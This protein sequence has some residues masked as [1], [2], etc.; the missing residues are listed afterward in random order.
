MPINSQLS[1]EDITIGEYILARLAQ[2]GL[3]EVHGV[4]G[5]SNL[6]FLDL[7][8]DH[9]DLN[10]VGCCN[11]LN[12]SYAADG[13]ARV[14]KAGIG[15]IVT[16]FGV[17]ELS[18]ANGIAGAYAEQVPILHLVG[19][20]ST[21][22]HAKNVIVHHS[23]G[24]NKLDTYAK[25]SGLITCAASSLLNHPKDAP[26]EIDRLLKAALTECRPVYLS[27]PGDLVDAKI[28]ASNL[29]LDLRQKVVE[30]L[31][32]QLNS[33][34]VHEVLDQ[35][36]NLFLESKK[37]VILLDGKCESFRIQTE[38][39]K[40]AEAIQVPVFTT[41]MAKTT[42]GENHPLFGGLYKGNLSDSHII[43]QVESSDMVIWIGPVASDINTASF[44]FNFKASE[45][46]EFH[47]SHTVVR[48]KQYAS[49]GFRNLLPLLTERLSSLPPK[50]KR[51]IRDSNLP[52]K[53]TKPMSM[54]KMIT[55]EEFWPLWAEHFFEPNDII[56]GETGTSAFGLLEV[57]IPD[58]ARLL[59]QML[60]ASIGWSTGACLGAAQAA[61]E[62]G[63]RTILFIG[64]GS[65]QISVQ[66]I[67]TMI[68][69]GVKPIIV[70]LNNDGY[71]I[72]RFVHGMTRKYNDIQPWKW[73]AILDLF[74]PENTTPTATYL[75]ETRKEFLDLLKNPE[76]RK[77]DRI[78]LV[79]VKLGREDGPD[80]LLKQ[81]KA[82]GLKKP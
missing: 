62:Q 66:E 75:V 31:R 59:C 21:A 24:D 18:A 53:L 68:R 6:R 42:I 47:A 14:S 2:L 79:E 43:Q 48:D 63:K 82:L 54:D 73:I 12:A 65:L 69:T 70:I 39:I 36:S 44:S 77:A 45:K 40:L 4:P 13:Y 49:I 37:P 20:P 81:I 72:E 11:E 61:E 10:W 22:I 80:M 52:A 35:I 1:H 55:Q 8:E 3:K 74:N 41:L 51:P 57:K 23:M 30:E 60:W 50:P 34:L 64:D 76:F 46:I 67:S 5:D 9:P 78:Q 19:I 58:G 7:I 33:N 38:A 71:A 29:R 27:L 16:T 32:L 25:I 56:V 15:C 28:S 26:D 17:G